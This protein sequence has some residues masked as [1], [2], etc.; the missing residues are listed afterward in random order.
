MAKLTIKDLD[1]NGKKVLIRVDFNV[2]L[3]DKTVADDMR[4]KA[5]LPTIKYV[6]DNGGSVIL[7]SHLGRPKGEVLEELRMNPVAKRLS[8]LLGIKVRKLDNCIGDDVKSRTGSMSPGEVVLLENLRFHSEE[9]SNDEQFAKQLAELADIYINDA[10]GTCHREHASMVGVPKYL[11]AA[12]GF[13]VQKEIESF[14]KIITDPEKPYVAIL[15]GAKVSDKI[16]LIENLF[17][18]VNKILIGGGMAYTFLK[19]KGYD[20]GNSILEEDK[21]DLALSLLEKSKEKNVEILLPVDHIIADEFSESANVKQID[22]ISIPEGWAGLDIG[23]KT[24]DNFKEA[25]ADAKTIVWNGPVGIFEMK[26][27]KKGTTEIANYIAG[28]DAMTVIGGGDTAAAVI[29]L[30]LKEKMSHVSTGG[31]ASLMFLEGKSLPGI[32]ALTE[33]QSTD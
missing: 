2:P 31:G 12:A 33:K 8:G 24:I 17:D 1:L 6:L 16:E 7:M 9:K 27:F 30:G 32:E 29:A 22:D 18:K 4:I 3:K 23:A 13:L 19:A 11:K 10:F 26:P 28:L 15:G 21:I 25:L 5:A 20:I 14:Q